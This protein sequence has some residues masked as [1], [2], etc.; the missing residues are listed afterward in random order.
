MFIPVVDKDNNPLMPTKPSRARRW[1]K[2]GLPVLKADR[3]SNSFL[4][5]RDILCST[6]Y[7]TFKQENTGNSCWNRPWQ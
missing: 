1:I 7:R 5:K 6:E 4:E 2:S 3:Q